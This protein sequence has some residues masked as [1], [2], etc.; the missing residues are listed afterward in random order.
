MNGAKR[1]ERNLMA[2]DGTR[3]VVVHGTWYCTDGIRY[4]VPRLNKKKRRALRRALHTVA[5]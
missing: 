1:I 4:P 2:S 5:K 3:Y